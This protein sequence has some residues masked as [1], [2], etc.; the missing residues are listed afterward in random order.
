LYFREETKVLHII[1]F[2]VGVPLICRNQNILTF[3]DL[4]NS[5]YRKGVSHCAQHLLSRIMDQ[6]LSVPEDTEVVIMLEDFDF[7]DGFVYAYYLASW[8]N[9]CIFWLDEVGY[10]YVTRYTRIC[11]T[12]SHIGMLHLPCTML[13]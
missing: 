5:E 8:K 11:T 7:C 1:V 6:K 12:E 10:D 3:V 13:S 9:K 2:D 4:Y